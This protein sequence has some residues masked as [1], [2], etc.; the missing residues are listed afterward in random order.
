[1]IAGGADPA[2]HSFRPASRFRS[3]H[4]RARSSTTRLERHED[5]HLS[6]V[7]DSSRPQCRELE[8]QGLDAHGPRPPAGAT[9]GLKP[10]RGA[11]E[12]YLRI[13]EQARLQPES[14]GKTLPVHELRPFEEG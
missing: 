10:K 12:T 9:G 13:L 4:D 11:V 6:V 5:H 8:S 7:A 14:R 1:M 2:R 3:L